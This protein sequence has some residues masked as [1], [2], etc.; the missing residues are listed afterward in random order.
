MLTMQRILDFRSY[1]TVWIMGQK[2]RQGTADR[3]AYYQL[4]GL[5]EI[6]DIYF[7]VPKPG[8]RSRGAAGKSK[9]VVAVE[10]PGNKPR[11]AALRQVPK[12]GPQRAKNK[13]RI[14]RS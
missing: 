6:D 7:G 11:F 9:V 4:A 2:I 10:T 8:K 13:R 12:L 14:A 3:D 5:I 1:K